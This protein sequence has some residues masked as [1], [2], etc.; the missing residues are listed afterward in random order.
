MKNYIARKIG[1]C[2]PC[3]LEGG[4]TQEKWPSTLFISLLFPP[5]F[6]VY[7]T[8]YQSNMPVCVVIRVRFYL[9]CLFAN[10]LSCAS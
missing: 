2:L 9:F 7:A 10:I 6:P 1:S 5:L 8:M 4:K 3:L